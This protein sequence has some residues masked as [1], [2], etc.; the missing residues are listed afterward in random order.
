MGLYRLSFGRHGGMLRL[1]DRSIA[2]DDHLSACVSEA[3]KVGALRARPPI[4]RRRVEQH[5]AYLAQGGTIA[6]QIMDTEHRG[7]SISLRVPTLTKWSPGTNGASQ[8]ACRAHAISVVAIGV[9]IKAEGLADTG[10]Q[11]GWQ[12]ERQLG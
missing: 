10:R 7:L 12:P 5:D 4:I 2:A 11:V 1:K 8:Q 9:E 6:R 3:A